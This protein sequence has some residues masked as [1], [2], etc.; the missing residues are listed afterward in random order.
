VIFL[1]T[2]NIHVYICT[3]QPH[4]DHADASVDIARLTILSKC[5]KR[6]AE[7]ELP[8]RQIF[9]DVC[10]TSGTLAQEVAF[11]EVETREFHVQASTHGDANSAAQS[12]E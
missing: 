1:N 5:R 6:G 7:E 9:D 10:R 3:Q 12:A 8:L 2:A 11:A 4:Y